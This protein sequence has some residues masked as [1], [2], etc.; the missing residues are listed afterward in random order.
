MTSVFY[1]AHESCCI[2][3]TADTR[4]R[5]IIETVGE[6]D[7]TRLTL[8]DEA[9]DVHIRCRGGDGEVDSRLAVLHGQRTAGLH[10]ADDAAN[11]PVVN[12]HRASYMQV[13]DG[14][15]LRIGNQAAREFL[16][17][18]VADGQR[19]TLSVEC[20][21][22]GDVAGLAV[23]H[24]EFAHM[25]CQIQIG[26]DTTVDGGIGT[27]V[28]HKLIPVVGIVDQ[29]KVVSVLGEIKLNGLHLV[30]SSQC[31]LGVWRHDDLGGSR[32]AISDV[33]AATTQSGI[34][35]EFPYINTLRQVEHL[36]LVALVEQVDADEVERAGQDDILHGT[37]LENIT[38]DVG[39]TFLDGQV[40]HGGTVGESPV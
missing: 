17:R 18:L 29:V 32:H 4:Y 24:T 16:T 26:S 39:D 25:G 31:C 8:T 36:Q 28:S 38:A 14:G 1:P 7:D 30:V 11:H 3:E 19:M 23:A 21:L 37:I 6:G 40:L 35:I 9:R 5:T 13:L 34:A 12:I 2:A 10:E 22:P 15:I 27:A 20:A 33:I